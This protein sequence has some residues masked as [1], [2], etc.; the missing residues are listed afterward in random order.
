MKV[1]RYHVNVLTK[2]ISVEFVLEDA[3]GNVTSGQLRHRV[4][5]PDAI[6]ELLVATVDPQIDTDVAEVSGVRS[7]T[8][9]SEL[10]RLREARGDVK[11]AVERLAELKA[12]QQ[13]AERRTEEAER[14]REAG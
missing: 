8:L 13:D 2:E 3:A 12:L 5:A 14:A 7:E 1:L 6:L 10:H 11:L 9:T 4:P